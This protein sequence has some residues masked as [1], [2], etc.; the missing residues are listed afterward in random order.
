MVLEE[1]IESLE[2]QLQP[3]PDDL[4]SW[5]NWFKE[6]KALYSSGSLDEDTY[7]INIASYIKKLLK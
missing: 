4:L 3:L 5:Q 6:R 1:E 2:Q 7:R